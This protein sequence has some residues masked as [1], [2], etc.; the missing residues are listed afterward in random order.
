[1]ICGSS[2][3]LRR[4]TVGFTCW[5][6]STSEASSDV[7]VSLRN[8]KFLVDTVPIHVSVVVAAVHCGEKAV[9]LHNGDNFLIS[10]D[11]LTSARANRISNDDLLVLMAN[12]LKIEP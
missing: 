10:R 4:R 9:I 11:S 5:L 2:E 1:M 7:F 8:G 6:S 3:N 12:G